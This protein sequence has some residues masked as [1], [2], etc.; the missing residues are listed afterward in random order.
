MKKEL[1]L[2]LALLELGA[3][4]YCGGSAV[5]QPVAIPLS[6]IPVSAGALNSV[7]SFVEGN[8]GELYITYGNSTRIGRIELQ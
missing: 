6:S 5:S 4:R 7:S 2:S 8:D 1:A 3:L